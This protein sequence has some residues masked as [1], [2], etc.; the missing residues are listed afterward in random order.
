MGTFRRADGTL[1]YNRT[2]HNI[3]SI[4]ADDGVYTLTVPL[5]T[6]L[7]LSGNGSPWNYVRLAAG[8][9]AVTHD[10]TETLR[11]LRQGAIRTDGE[12][13]WEW[14]KTLPVSADV[15]DDSEFVG[16]AVA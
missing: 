9:W 16:A 8:V 11:L 12:N 3:A 10:R 4:A 6:S 13:L 15:A 1:F 14:A 5:L 7:I 2:L